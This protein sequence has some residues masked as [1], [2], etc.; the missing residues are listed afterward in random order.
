MFCCGYKPGHV[1]G[2][3]P[4]SLVNMCTVTIYSPCGRSKNVSW[5]LSEIWT[6]LFRE[7]ALDIHRQGTWSRWAAVMLCRLASVDGGA[8]ASICMARMAFMEESWECMVL[9]LSDGKSIN[10]DAP[11]D[12]LECR[13]S[14]V[15]CL[16]LSRWMDWLIRCPLLPLNHPLTMASTSTSTTKPLQNIYYERVSTSVPRPLCIQW[17]LMSGRK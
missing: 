15:F 5:R 12:R 2:P 4:L 13:F 16:F 10:V 1:S 17:S 8:H 3:A 9:G 11:Y 7:S 6:K 14:A